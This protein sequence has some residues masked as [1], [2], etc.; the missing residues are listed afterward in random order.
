MDRC[1]GRRIRRLSVALHVLFSEQ[2]NEFKEELA[3]PSDALRS[4][5]AVCLSLNRPHA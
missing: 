4:S 5:V 2:E 1:F 3:Q